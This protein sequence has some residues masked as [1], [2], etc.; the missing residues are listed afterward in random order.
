MANRFPW[1]QFM[2]LGLG[3]LRLPPKDF[4]AATPREIASAFGPLRAGLG[5]DDLLTLMQ[6]F[7]DDE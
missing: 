1:A 6:Q 4:W 2:R 5:R 7:P 3:I